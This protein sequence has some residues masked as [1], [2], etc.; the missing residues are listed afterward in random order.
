MVFKVRFTLQVPPNKI[1]HRWHSP[2]TAFRTNEGHYEF[3][4]MSFGLCNVPASFQSTMNIL[5]QPY[6][7]K[8]V[9]VFFDDI[10]VYSK[11]LENHI[12]HLDIVIQC[13]M[14]NQFFLKRNKCLFAQESVEYLDHI[15]S[16]DGIDSNLEKICAMIAWSTPTTLKQLREFLGLT[17]F[18]WKFV[19]PYAS[20]VAPLIN[21]LK[22]DSFTWYEE[23]QRSFE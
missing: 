4:V 15:I 18:Y 14:T 21:L 2:K 5:F 3:L 23:E 13:L 8:F 17:G 1:D 11:S 7:R 19:Q 9:I 12:S 22:R 10:L 16:K 20:I 6:L